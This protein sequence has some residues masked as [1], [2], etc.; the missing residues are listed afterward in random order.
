[1]N[2]L[3][4]FSKSQEWFLYQPDLSIKRFKVKQ[5]IL[6]C[7]LIFNKIYQVPQIYFN[8]ELTNGEPMCNLKLENVSR[9]VFFVVH[10][11]C[12]QF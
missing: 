12:I 7:H 10:D 5:G 9:E 4:E 3:K 6:E 11:R 1:M 8:Y 2:L